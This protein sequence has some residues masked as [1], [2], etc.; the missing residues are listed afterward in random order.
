VHGVVVT[1]RNKTFAYVVVERRLVFVGDFV[2]CGTMFVELRRSD[3]ENKTKNHYVSTIVTF[4][5]DS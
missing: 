4:R 5:G 3:D 1:L 2:D